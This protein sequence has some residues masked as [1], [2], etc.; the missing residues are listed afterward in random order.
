MDMNFNTPTKIIIGKNCVEN[1]AELFAKLGKRCVI[2]TGKNSADTCGAF[3]D[4]K[5]ALDS[6]GVSFVRYN[7]IC[8]N[9][10][11]ASCR[12]AAKLAKEEKV[13]FVVG[14]GGGSP[15]D[16]AK[17]VAALASDPDMDEE[18]FYSSEFSSVL[19]VACIGTTAGTGSEV[20]PIGVITGSDNCKRSIR[21]DELYPAFCLGDAKYLMFM[22]DE[23]TRYTALDALCHCIES[24]FN[25]TSDEKSRDFAVKG[26]KI[27]S[28]SLEK[29]GS[30]AE[31]TYEDREL[32][33]TASIYAGLAISTT[34]TA[35]PH[36]L[37]Y[38]ISE[39]CGV[40]H[41]FACS[42]FL[43]DFVR[44][45]IAYV[46]EIANEF[47]AATGMSEGKI[48]RLLKINNPPRRPVWLG[49]GTVDAILPRYENHKNFQKSYGRNDI[50]VARKFLLRIT[51]IG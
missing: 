10:T 30:G 8:P 28:E 19:P 22:T 9:P 7:E 49:D 17:A 11:I 20:T 16:A 13:D 31:L 42:M 29:T 47:F 35:I 3:A 32:I 37:S 23:I 39:A 43:D 6:V 44:H 12:E 38:F 51:R 15:L 1:N 41:G 33:Y 26:A 46:P 50:E 2:V 36:A 40:P 48:K 24:Y 14:I 27:L 34:G 5:K 21:A 18:K 4:V 45:N 25:R